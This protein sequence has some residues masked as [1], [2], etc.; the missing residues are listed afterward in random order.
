MLRKTVSGMILTLLLLG[1][2]M[3]VFNISQVSCVDSWVWV[4]DT[5]TGAYGEAVVGTGTA[6]YIARGT[7]FYC[8]FPVNDSFA[9][10]ASPPKPDGYAFKTGTA[11]AWD[12]NDYIY[13]LFGA[14]TDDSRRWF[15]RYSISQNSWEALAN[16]PAD[17]GEGD[18]M[19]WV[20]EP[21]N[22]IYAT[23]GG[24]QRPTYLMF[25][26]PSTNNWSDTPT[27]PPAGM[28]D[29]AS[30]VWTSDDFLYAL[31]GEYYEEEP[32]CDFWRYS[33][34]DDVWTV[35]ADIPAYAHDGGV[36]GVGDGGSLLYIGFWMANQTDYIYALSGN[37]AYPEKPVIPDNR[38]YRYTISTNSWERLA[39][40]PFGVGYYVGCRLG[41]ADGHIY[42]WQGTPSTWEGGGDDLAKYLSSPPPTLNRYVY[43]IV[44]MGDSYRVVIETD[45]VVSRLDYNNYSFS[46]SWEDFGAFEN[47]TIP[48]ALNET[49]IK[50]IY[51]Q[52]SQG[53][54]SSPQLSA[55]NT[56]YFI[57]GP[58]PD[59]GHIVEVFFGLPTIEIDLSAP[60]VALGYYVNITGVVRYKEKPVNDVGVRLMWSSGGLPNEIATLAP[61]SKGTF[62]V[63]W[64]PHA[65]GSFYITA[66]LLIYPFP[67]E[68]P[69]PETHA[70]L[71][72]SLPHEQSV[73]SVVS[74]STITALTFNSTS[75]ILSFLANGPEGTTG[76]AKVFISKQL[77][78]DINV[79]KVY[80]DDAQTDYTYR[81]ALDSWILNIIYQH[82][83]RKVQIVL[84]EFPSP[85]TV[86]LLFA[87]TTLISAILLKKKRKLHQFL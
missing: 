27:D 24:E 17:Q 61:S 54:D 39:D 34:T 33:L 7:Y 31:R 73:F 85:I 30:L 69:P 28:G 78:T 42:A 2:L 76:Y 8:Y 11:L 86:L 12:F 74:N 32:L 83:T 14:A 26:D 15:Y 67:D 77:L 29:G 87:S 41:Y 64:I 46:I 1:I 10:L 57:S 47:I 19:T 52:M 21:Y 35:M 22:C 60:T 16:T 80:V 50:V 75:Y 37:Q 45:G 6:L 13:A 72:I 49:S 9:E 79:L 55:N 58:N 40:L 66:Q 18:A 36:G 65:T 4:R 81:S 3:L 23:I 59:F 25:Y 20:G 84:P 48:R 71:S 44:V 68:V 70:C 56:H 62:N 5:V 82:S 43:D 63:S 38:T 51:H 53:W